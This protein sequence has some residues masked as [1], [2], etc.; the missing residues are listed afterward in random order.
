M[1]DSVRYILVDGCNLQYRNEESIKKSY[2]IK[3]CPQCLASIY[4]HGGLKIKK[5]EYGRL[6]TKTEIISQPLI[7]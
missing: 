1:I 7:M 5:Q 6:N 2:H 4:I 3:H